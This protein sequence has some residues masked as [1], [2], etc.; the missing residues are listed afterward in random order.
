MRKAE[1]GGRRFRTVDLFSGCGGLS[2]GFSKAGFKVLAAYDNWELANTVY[3]RNFKHPVHSIDLSDVPA[4]S[5]H[6]Q[7]Y[8]P[9]VIIGG[10][11]CQDFS[12]A[13][14]RK[15]SERA[16]LTVAFARIVQAVSPDLVVMENVYSIEKTRTLKDA[17]AIF[18]GSGYG[19]TARVIDASLTGVPQMRKRFFLVA[20]KEFPDEAFGAEL[21]GN[22][23]PRPLTVFDY[24]GDSLGTKYYYAHP[25][26]YKRRAVF[27]V[28]EP[29]AT[30][31]RVNRPIP[32]YY[33]RHPADKA[34][35]SPEI[36]PLTTEE[37]QEIQTFPPSF[38]F[39][40]SK[41]QQEHMIANAVPVKL[42]QY[43]GEQ[44][45]KVYWNGGR[46]ARSVVPPSSG[47]SP[48]FSFA[49]LVA[50]SKAK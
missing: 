26:S 36:R 27:S 18:R 5:R 46:H 11:P 35:I 29:S 3:R 6:I 20:A 22:L 39:C 12:I 19:I 9:K 14:K 34:P 16:S 31:R 24:F 41:S 49:E 47:E 45:A 42:A 1:A 17:V 25:R 10:P 44:V 38:K 23:S 33:V 40:G 4:A 32:K 28:H 15:E 7:R 2:L 30:I 13:G 37:R 21:D 48:G 50:A 43:V 8:S